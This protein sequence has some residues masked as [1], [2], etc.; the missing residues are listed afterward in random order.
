MNHY[1]QQPFV[2]VS[3]RQ[4][5]PPEGY[6]MYPYAPPGYPLQGATLPKI[7]LVNNTNSG[8]RR[9]GFAAAA[10]VSLKAEI[11]DRDF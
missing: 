7:L 5:Y 9:T 10:M 6:L 8:S 4:G 1:N 2:V 3:P 11:F